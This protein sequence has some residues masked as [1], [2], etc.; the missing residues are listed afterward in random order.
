VGTGRRNQS[1]IGTLVERTSRYVRL[2]HLSN[3]LLAARPGLVG[4]HSTKA[5]W[6]LYRVL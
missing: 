1:A 4:N 5:Q 3:G 2:V 6:L